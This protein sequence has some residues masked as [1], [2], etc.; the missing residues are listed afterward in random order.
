MSDEESTS[1]NYGLL[2]IC[3][4]VNGEAAMRKGRGERE[5]ISWARLV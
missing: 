4:S 1:W 2:N 3:E 5:V